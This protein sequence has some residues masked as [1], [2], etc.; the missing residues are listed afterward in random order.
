MSSKAIEPRKVSKA[1]LKFREA[2]E[3]LKVGKPDI[4]PKGAYSGE[5]DRSFRG[6]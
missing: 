1:E 4:L 6:S 2:F 5:R 3:R